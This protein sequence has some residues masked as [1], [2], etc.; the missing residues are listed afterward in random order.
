MIEACKGDESVKAMTENRGIRKDKQT[1]LSGDS[2]DYEKLD[3]KV[4]L[5]LHHL[6]SDLQALLDKHG[7]IE[8]PSPEFVQEVMLLIG[9]NT[10]EVSK[11]VIRAYLHRRMQALLRLKSTDCKVGPKLEES[12]PLSTKSVPRR[13]EDSESVASKSKQSRSWLESRLNYRQLVFKMIQ[14]ME[15]H[16]N[17][18]IFTV[19]SVLGLSPEALSIFSDSAQIASLETELDDKQND[20]GSQIETQATHIEESKDVI[21]QSSNAS[22]RSHKTILSQAVK[23][24]T[25]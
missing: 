11:Q 18:V 12:T 10:R 3:L 21:S 23:D 4:E 24:A 14:D 15:T 7:G 25:D 1:G 16:C 22:K 5:L 9:A 17:D 8:N 2:K 6:Q 13:S 20:V 19:Q